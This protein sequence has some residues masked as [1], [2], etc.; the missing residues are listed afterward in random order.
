MVCRHGQ[1]RGG[2]DCGPGVSS[3]RRGLGGVTANE[4]QRILVDESGLH[5]TPDISLRRNN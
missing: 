5:P 2:E 1:D 4:V 3:S